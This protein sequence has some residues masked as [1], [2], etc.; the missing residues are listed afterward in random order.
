MMHTIRATEDNPFPITLHGADLLLRG[1]RERKVQEMLKVGFPVNAP[2]LV[3]EAYIEARCTEAL[4]TCEEFNP[5]YRR[6]MYQ[7]ILDD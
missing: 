1:T 4:S 6:E 5:D 3:E 7:A 2:I